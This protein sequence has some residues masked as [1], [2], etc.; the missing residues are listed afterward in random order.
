MINKSYTSLF[1]VLLLSLIVISCSAN[2]STVQVPESQESASISASTKEQSKSEWDKLVS[3]AKAEGKVVIL[4]SMGPEVKQVLVKAFQD[5]YGIEVDFL[6]MRG[7]EI[8]TK[9]QNERRAGIYANDLTIGGATT[10]SGIMAPNGWVD[11][12][13]SALILP[14]VKDPAVWWAGKLP[15]SGYG[16]GISVMK[17]VN[18]PLLI[19]TDQVKPGE[20]KSYRDLLN[21]KWKGKIVM[22]DPSVTG[23]GGKL[24]NYIL[25]ENIAGGEELLRGLVKQEPVISADRR[26]VAE[27][28]ARGKYSI[29]ICARPEM[30]KPLMD[31]GL[32][33]SW[34]TP[35]EGTYVTGGGGFASILNKPQHPNAAKLFLNWVLTR[36]AA[37]LWQG[38]TDTQS[39]RVDVPIDKLSQDHIRKPGIKYFDSDVEEFEKQSTE[40][41]KLIKEIFAPVLR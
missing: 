6:V 37:V 35:Q 19:N 21:P 16:G 22:D 11:S 38:A 14:E 7:A 15:L 18:V 30:V 31:L 27:W 17:Y 10:L 41:F 36:E 32:P 5:K 39:A 12:V 28:V 29:A 34:V 4:T 25:R 8:A 2:P 24:A 40:G 26:L 23:S 13:E 9:L 1:L 33:V 3:A 20:I